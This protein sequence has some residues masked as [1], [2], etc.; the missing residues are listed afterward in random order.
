MNK[1]DEQQI[2]NRMEVLQEALNTAM[3][4]LL[5]IQSEHKLVVYLLSQGKEK[6][7]ER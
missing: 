2:L 5:E 3:E 7:K 1:I 6:N 4:A